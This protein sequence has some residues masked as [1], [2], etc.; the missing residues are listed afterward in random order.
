VRE[1]TFIAGDWGTTSL[2]LAL[3]RGTKILDRITGPGVATQLAAPQAN[4]RSLTK[5]WAAEY[6]PLPALLCGMVG[7]RIGWVETPY[8]ACPA[9]PQSLRRAAI[10]FTHEGATVSIVPGLSCNNPLGAPDVMRGE[11]TQIFGAV[12][13]SPALA[14][15][16]HL[17][18][19][20]GTHTK[21]AIVENGTVQSFLSAMTGEIF[22]LLRDHSTLSKAGG[23]PQTRAADGFRKGLARLKSMPAGAVVH[24]LFEVRSRQL[25][26]AVPEREAIEYLSGLLI[27]ADVAAALQWFGAAATVVVIGEPALAARY[28]DAL[29][30]F[31]A[32]SCNIDAADASLAGLRVIFGDVLGGE[33]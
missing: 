26:E 33:N 29:T 20:P 4:F 25:L 23:N 14:S 28:N 19:L 11:E 15:G 16:R 1:T 6:G 7:A 5:I 2:R 24:L 10:H 13:L 32:E 12:A 30:A 27:G 8:L 3:C 17:L 31:G 22:A 21:W 9:E 18:V